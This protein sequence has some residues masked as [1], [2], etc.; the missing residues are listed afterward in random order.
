[1]ISSKLSVVVEVE[2]L[3]VE[4]QLSPRIT[5][6]IKN[7]IQSSIPVIQRQWEQELQSTAHKRAF[8]QNLQFNSAISSNGLSGYLQMPGTFPNMG[9]FN[10]D[11]KLFRKLGD[12]NRKLE[13]KRQLSFPGA[14]SNKWSRRQLKAATPQSGL[15]RIVRSYHI[16]NQFQYYNLRRIVNPSDSM[17]WWRPEYGRANLSTKLM[18]F[19][20]VTFVDMLTHHLNGLA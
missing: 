1:M 3:M 19:A 18:P 5:A 13:D 14:K 6:T 20:R 15:N 4:N 7:S 16:N 9:T 12:T 17:S 11:A 2:S 10:F 8:L